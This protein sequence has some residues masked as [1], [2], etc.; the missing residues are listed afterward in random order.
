VPFGLAVVLRDLLEPALLPVF[1]RLRDQERARAWRLVFVVS[2]LLVA[3]VVFVALLA[4][5]NAERLAHLLAPGFQGQRIH[6]TATLI[7]WLIPS[8]LFLGLANLAGTILH[9]DKRF[10]LPAVGD[11]VFRSGPVAGLLSG[12]GLAG[13]VA[14]VLLGSLGKL[15]TQVAGLRRYVPPFLREFGQWEPDVRQVGQ[16]AAPLSVG[17]LLAY[18]GVPLVENAFASTLAGGSVASLTFAR[19]IAETLGSILPYTLGVVAFPYFAQMVLRDEAR[20]LERTL[21]Q[22]LRAILF[23]YLPITVGVILLRVPL[24]QLL[25]QRGAFDA[26]ATQQTAWPLLWYAVGLV[27]MAIEPVLVHF[28]FAQSDMVTPIVWDVIS[29]VAGVALTA[30]LIGPLGAGGIAL[31]TSLAKGIKVV[32]LLLHTARRFPSWRLSDL[33]RFALRLCAAVA[34]MGAVVLAVSMWAASSLAGAG[35]MGAALHL[36]AAALAGGAVYLALSWVFVQK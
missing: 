30:L 24:V 16:L 20:E 4:F 35:T 14:G 3:G 36:L 28:F 23:F 34:G 9:A 22:A 18:V 6:L 8:L 21:H 15:V 32:A 29:F 19:K 25:F 2:A 33:A 5:G 17:L 10:V 31:A 7:R 27:P 11:V 1:V 26:Q 13:L 12:A